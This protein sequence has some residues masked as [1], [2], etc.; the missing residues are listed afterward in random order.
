MTNGFYKLEDTLLYAP[1]SV[2]NDKYSLDLNNYSKMEYPIDG[3]YYFD[4]LENALMFFSLVEIKQ[5]EEK[6]YDERAIP[7]KQSFEVKATEVVIES[8]ILDVR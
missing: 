7:V 4:S 5:V 1:N 3:W 2:E 6:V 8:E